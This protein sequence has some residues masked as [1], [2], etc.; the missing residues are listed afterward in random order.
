MRSIYHPPQVDIIPKVYHPFR[1]ERISLKNDKFLPKLVVFH[2]SPCWTRTNDLRINSPSNCCGTRCAPCRQSGCV[3]HRPRPLARVAVSAP[4]GA[5]LAPYLLRYAQPVSR[6]TKN[7]QHRYNSGRRSQK[8]TTRLGGLFLAP[9]VGLE[10]TTCG[11][12]EHVAPPQKAKQAI[13]KR[14]RC[15]VFGD[16]SA[17]EIPKQVFSKMTSLPAS[18]AV[19]P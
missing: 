17:T 1:K 16:H 4:G 5:P 18:V 8:K 10:P 3:A 14:D 7:T 11:L 9:L 12:T 2:G 19:L 15:L 13:K 6:R